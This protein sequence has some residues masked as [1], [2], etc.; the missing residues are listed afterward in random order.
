MGDGRV[1]EEGTRAH[2]PASQQE[3]G[4][5]L[6]HAARMLLF[7]PDTRMAVMARYTVMGTRHRA[8]RPPA[9]QRVHEPCSCSLAPQHPQATATCC[10]TPRPGCAPGLSWR[11]AGQRVV[12]SRERRGGQFLRVR[13]RRLSDLWA[14]QG[15]LC[16]VVSR[17]P[18]H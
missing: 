7:R 12:A 16:L 15:P 6:T 13:G 8:P 4:W 5:K 1:M 10:P 9:G 2:H 11:V 18:S 14:A 3:Q 17:P